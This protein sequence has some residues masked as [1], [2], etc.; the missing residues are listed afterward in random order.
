MSK[1]LP[2]PSLKSIKPGILLLEPLSRRGYG[3]GVIVF[4][5]ET[6]YSSLEDKI[7]VKDNVP[8]TF[9]KWAEEGYTVVEITEAAFAAHGAKDAL[10]TAVEVLRSCDKCTPQETFGIVGKYE[11][12]DKKIKI[13]SKPHDSIRTPALE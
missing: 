6:Q 8:S 9:M 1:D 7:T 13:I 3:P 10:D 2:S 5:P 12:H 11:K 4:C